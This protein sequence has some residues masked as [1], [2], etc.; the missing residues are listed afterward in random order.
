MIGALALSTISYS[1][2]A[3]TPTNHHKELILPG[4]SF[5][6]DGKPAFILWP[7]VEKRREPQAWVMY[8]PTLPG[9]PD[10]HENG[11]MSSS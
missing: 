4:E 5:L 3:Q 2:S 6:V 9:Y 10:K 11:C 8:A 7:A 1:V